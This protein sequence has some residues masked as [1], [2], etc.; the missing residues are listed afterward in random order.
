MA[1]QNAG[2]PSSMANQNAGHPSSMANQNAG[3]GTINTELNT[4]S[5]NPNIF[6]PQGRNPG[7]NPNLGTVNHGLG[8]SQG[9][10]GSAGFMNSG[11]N[12][13]FLQRTGTLNTQMGMPLG[14]NLNPQMNGY[15]PNPGQLNSTL[16]T[17]NTAGARFPAWDMDIPSQMFMQ[18][19]NFEQLMRAQSQG[20]GGVGDV[21][22][23]G[24]SAAGNVMNSTRLSEDSSHKS[25]TLPKHA[26]A[27]YRNFFGCK[28]ENFH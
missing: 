10:V 1:N 15:P 24:Q 11:M 17:P 7:M 9:N 18:A 21:S 16:S 13:N 19:I 28:N 4:G 2:H 12:S 5:M 20:G 6:Q 25:G 3:Q 26:H 23:G 14:P 22:F 27:I 8:I